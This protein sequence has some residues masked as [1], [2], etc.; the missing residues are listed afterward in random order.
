MKNHNLLFTLILFSQIII[1]QESDCFKNSTGLYWP[2]KVGLERN[3]I[4]GNNTYKSLF[5]GD[6]IQL[7]GKHYLVETKEYSDGKIKKS[8]WRD[9][10]GAIYN[11]NK[12]KGLGSM[13]LP[14][15]PKIGQKW[16]STDGTWT[17]EIIS[18]NSIYSTPFCEFSNL[19]E[20]ETK[21]SERKGLIYNLFYLKGKG[22]IALNVNGVP[23]TYIKP[24][25]KLNDK[26]FI[27]YGCQDSINEKETKD[28]N[29]SKIYSHIKTNFKSPS[30][31][32]KGKVIAKVFIGTNGYVNKVKIISGLKKAKKQETEVIRVIKSLP[33]FIPAQ[34]DDN[35]PIKTSFVIPIVF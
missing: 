5:N 17:Y 28:C 3:Y 9:N 14:S 35:K 23:Y 2:V 33:K 19:L 24:N 13:E 25:R 34:I 22:M 7:N 8:Y 4:S 30:K 32:K 10:K 29:Y 20:V 1:A 31:L 11:F 27:A 26:D 21:N 16:K 12:K 15:N 18:F 6:S